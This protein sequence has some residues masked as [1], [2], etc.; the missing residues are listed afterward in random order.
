MSVCCLAQVMFFEDSTC[1]IRR[2]T[3]PYFGEIVVLRAKKVV[4]EKMAT[5]NTFGPILINGQCIG[6]EQADGT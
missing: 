2:I 1:L 5:I 6:Y 3:L 4:M